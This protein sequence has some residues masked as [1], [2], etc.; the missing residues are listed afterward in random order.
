MRIE[1]KK[2]HVISRDERIVNFTQ[3][4]K[5]KKTNKNTHEQPKTP[6]LPKVLNLFLRLGPVYNKK[7]SISNK[8]RH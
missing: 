7:K 1:V 6:K 3:F 2:Y 8:F 4:T 5:I